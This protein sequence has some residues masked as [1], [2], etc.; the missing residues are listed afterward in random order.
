MATPAS[1]HI[2]Y[3]F[4]P[5]FETFEIFGALEFTKQS[6]LSPSI[7]VSLWYVFG[8][9]YALHNHLSYRDGLPFVNRKFTLEPSI[10]SRIRWAF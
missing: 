6:I 9:L 3:A 4:Y 1:I 2:L 7:L 5:S 8:A 10:G